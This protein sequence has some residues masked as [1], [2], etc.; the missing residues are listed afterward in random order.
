[1]AEMSSVMPQLGT[2]MMP[3]ITESGEGIIKDI[4]FGGL[5]GPLSSSVSKKIKMPYFI[6][7]C[8]PE[9]MFMKT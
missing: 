2:S 5:K 4:C 9:T 1:M 3:R 6:L 7:E 8:A